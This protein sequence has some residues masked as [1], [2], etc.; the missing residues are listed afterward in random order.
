MPRDLE[1]HGQQR[2][3]LEMSR[4][5]AEAERRYWAVRRE[6]VRRRL[7]QTRHQ[8]ARP[9]EDRKTAERLADRFEQRGRL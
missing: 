3:G 1:D 4:E 8:T 7:R 5:A 6:L 2:K 9:E